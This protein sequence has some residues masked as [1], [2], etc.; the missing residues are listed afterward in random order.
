MSGTLRGRRRND[1]NNRN[2]W[3][4]QRWERYSLLLWNDTQIQFHTLIVISSVFKESIG[5]REEMRWIQLQSKQ[6]N[7]HCGSIS[8]RA[9][10]KTAKIRIEREKTYNDMQSL[11]FVDEIQRSHRP[12]NSGVLHMRRTDSHL[13][14]IITVD[15]FTFG[16]ALGLT[17]T[18]HH[19]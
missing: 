12:D 6:I 19:N 15:V 7:K 14:C 17:Q 13:A 18:A 9:H 2:M 5:F 4:M 10:W 11:C 1:M 3:K 16:R 8:T